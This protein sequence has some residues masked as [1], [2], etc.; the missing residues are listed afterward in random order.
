MWLNKNRHKI[1]MPQKKRVLVSVSL[2]NQ[3]ASNKLNGIISF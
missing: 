2:F 1:K 3:V